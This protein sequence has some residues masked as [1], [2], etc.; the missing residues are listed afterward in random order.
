[1]LPTV[2]EPLCFTS[3]PP[4]LRPMSLTLVGVENPPHSFLHIE[5]RPGGSQM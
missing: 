2:F 4:Q 5:D 1:M 3:N